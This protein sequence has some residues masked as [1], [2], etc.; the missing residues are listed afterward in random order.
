[1]QTVEATA[2]F[3]QQL[4]SVAQGGSKICVISYRNW[5]HNIVSLQIARKCCPYYAGDYFNILL[6]PSITFQTIWTIFRSFGKMEKSKDGRPI[7]T[8]FPSHVTLST[9][10]ADLKGVISRC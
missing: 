4:Q 5:Q 3:L 8:Q 1:M 10:D 9:S 2:M 7:M 6:F